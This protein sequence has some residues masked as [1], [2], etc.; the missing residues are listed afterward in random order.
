MRLPLLMQVPTCLHASYRDLHACHMQ[1]PVMNWQGLKVMK[2]LPC[3]M[4][5]FEHVRH[6]RGE[7]P[8]GTF[9]TTGCPSTPYR[10]PLLAVM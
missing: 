5:P 7:R 3:M 8:C 6:M 4:Q 1:D 9:S 10:M 2:L